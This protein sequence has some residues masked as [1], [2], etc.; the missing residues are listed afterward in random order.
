MNM[1]GYFEEIYGK[2]EGN[3]DTIGMTQIS[4]FW[5]AEATTLPRALPVKNA[6]QK[7]ARFLPP[8][9]SDAGQVSP[10][11][12]KRNIGNTVRRIDMEPRDF[13]STVFWESGDEKPRNRA[14]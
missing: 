5:V 12:F 13:R 14:C 3:T 10:F 2:G 8:G 9:K 7:S 11:V 1:F 4:L 6:G